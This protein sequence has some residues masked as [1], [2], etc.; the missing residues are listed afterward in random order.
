MGAP[1]TLDTGW[2]GIWG[3]PGA[4]PARPPPATARPLTE[5]AW[6]RPSADEG[7]GPGERLA[8]EQQGGLRRAAQIVAVE[9]VASWRI[10]GRRPRRLVRHGCAGGRRRI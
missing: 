2:A 3:A 7:V 8:D 4:V 5:R 9:L 1:N 6:P 10:E